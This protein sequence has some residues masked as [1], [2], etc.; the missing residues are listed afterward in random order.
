M[1]IAVLGAGAWGC[2]I[3]H[4]MKPLGDVSLWGRGEARLPVDI[5]RRDMNAALLE[6]D[7][8]YVAVPTQPLRAFLTE[9]QN[10]LAACEAPLI[11]CAKGLEQETALTVADIAQEM[12]PRADIA[13]L[14]GPSFAADVL[15]NQ[16]TAL[17]LAHANLER[18][19]ALAQ[20][21]STPYFR[22]Y[23]STDVRGVALG[24]ALK[25]V[26]AIASGL[27]T[28]AGFGESAAAALL[29]RGFAEMRRFAAAHG[30]RVETLMGLSGFGDL[31][32]TATSKTSRNFAFGSALAKGE[33]TGNALVEGALTA[34]V[35]HTSALTLGLHMPLTRAVV[36]V[37]QAPDRLFDIIQSVLS[38]RTDY[39]E[40]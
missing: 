11:F 20:Q 14:S 29:T 16:P 34:P 2:A 17:V 19:L 23:A 39:K 3:A 4:A 10:A 26:L 31:I 8:V 24:G 21:L 1:K 15:R 22:L 13:L 32:L 18:G 25:N 38:E 40:G 7:A 35:V 28:G 12:L 37:L 33:P 5:P 9:H 36:E 27:A 6:A 30:A